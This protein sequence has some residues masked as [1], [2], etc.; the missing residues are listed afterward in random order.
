MNQFSPSTQHLVLNDANNCMGSV[1]VHR[2]QYKLNLLS[3][4][5]FPLLGDGGTEVC[6][7]NEVIIIN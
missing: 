2:I 1:A 4:E 6:E 3:N 5:I 7:A